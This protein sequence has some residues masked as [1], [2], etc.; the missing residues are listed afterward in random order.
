MDRYILASTTT[1][2]NVFLLLTFVIDHDD[3]PRW[4]TLDP[5]T[6]SGLRSTVRRLDNSG[7]TLARVSRTPRIRSAGSVEV[8]MTSTLGIILARTTNTETP[9]LTRIS[10]QMLGRSNT[11]SVSNILSRIPAVML[12]PEQYSIDCIYLI[13]D[14]GEL[15]ILGSSVVW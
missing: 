14:S 15:T 11:W 7:S 6:W 1:E 2:N 12:G 13:P 10:F 5:T 9:R 8:G 3:V 4:D